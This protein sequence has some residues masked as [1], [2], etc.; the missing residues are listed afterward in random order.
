MTRQ[1][2]SWPPWFLKCHQQETPVYPS[3]WSTANNRNLGRPRGLRIPKRPVCLDFSSR[4]DECLTP[5]Q[6]YSD[7]ATHTIYKTWP[8]TVVCRINHFLM[9]SSP[10]FPD[11]V[12]TAYRCGRTKESSKAVGIGNS[13]E[14]CAIPRCTRQGTY[15]LSNALDLKT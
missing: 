1:I 5:Q 9:H 6:I 10:L 12:G 2:R 14:D 13:G 8:P 11:Q 15:G 3:G 4:Y 7:C